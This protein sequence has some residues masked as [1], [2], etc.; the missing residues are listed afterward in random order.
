VDYADVK[1]RLFVQSLSGEV[2]KWFKALSAASIQDFV[3]FEMSFIT[4]WGDKKN[5]LQLL[6]QYNYMKRSPE[7]TMQEFSAHFMR[8]YNSIPI[9]F[10]PP[11]GVVQLQYADSFYSD[12]IL[13]LRERRSTNL[14]VMMS[15]AIKVKVNMMALGKIK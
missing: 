9:E 8:V 1:M 5:P 14:Y 2:R 13:L 15:D 6:T 11:P 3:A 7:D 12:F 4:I 10:Q